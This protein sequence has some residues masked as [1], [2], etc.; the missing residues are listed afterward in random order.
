MQHLATALAIAVCHIEDLASDAD[1]D[2]K[3]LE[4]IAVEIQQ[5][6]LDDRRAVV[7]ALNAVGR[8]ELVDGMG[9]SSI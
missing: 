7:E 9:I 3:A 4:A 2:V 8:P 6:S 1:A 5:G